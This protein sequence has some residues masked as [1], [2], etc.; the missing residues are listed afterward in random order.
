MKH[1]SESNILSAPT[2]NSLPGLQPTSW[3]LHSVQ[4]AYYIDAN[5]LNASSQIT[6]YQVIRNSKGFPLNPRILT[7]EGQWVK[8]GTSLDEI[9]FPSFESAKYALKEVLENETH[10]W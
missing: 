3:E 4:Y 2:F 8:F 10:S 7:T 6:S 5:D 9:E 1:I